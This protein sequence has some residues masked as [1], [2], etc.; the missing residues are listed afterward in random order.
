MLNSWGSSVTV[1]SIDSGSVIV[2]KATPDLSWARVDRV[3]LG[4]VVS[5]SSTFWGGA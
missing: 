1:E 5:D 4:K 3:F 2:Q